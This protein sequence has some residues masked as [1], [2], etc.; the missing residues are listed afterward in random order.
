MTAS[1]GSTDSWIDGVAED[2]AVI[3]GYKIVE[4]AGRVK[5]MH[6]VLPGT[7]ASWTFEI[8][9]DRFSVVVTVAPPSSAKG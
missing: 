4:M 6:Q 3:I 9:N 1:H 5:A 2:D 7:Q 8:E